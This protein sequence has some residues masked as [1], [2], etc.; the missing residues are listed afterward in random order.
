MGSM[1]TKSL[2][3][4]V[5]VA[6]TALVASCATEPPPFP[7]PH[8]GGVNPDSVARANDAAYVDP[9]PYAAAVT[10]VEIEPGRKMEIWYPAAP[11][12][13]VGHSPD[14]YHLRDFL[15]ALITDVLPAS[16][17]P[18]FTTTAFRDLPASPGGPFPMVLFSH[19]A[20]SYRDQSSFLTAHLASWGFV[21]I[22]PDYFERGIQTLSGLATVPVP[23][24]S[25]AD[26]TQLAVDEAIALNTGTGTLAGKIDTTR[27]FPIGHS[28]GGSQSTQ[29]AG[30]R[31]DVQS[32]IA[33]SS[34]V[35]LTPSLFN[36]TP[37][38][39][40]ALADPNKTVMWLVGAND[41]VA[42][43]GGVQTAFNY[44]AGER[45]LVVVPLSGH[46]NAMTDICEISRPEGGL[47]GLANT[48]LPFTLPEFV[49]N[50]A[51]DGCISPPNYQGPQVWPIVRQFVTAELRYRSGLD[52]SPVGLGSGVVNQFA[53]VPTYSHN[54]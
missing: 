39:P 25:S 18:S 44:S 37:T 3:A 28:A 31:T 20:I 43:P 2:A 12:S 11:A 13:A 10:T 36:P 33:M 47:V 22:S 17:D 49:T 54:E 32:W 16:V 9:G 53:V 41:N 34:G 51:N 14:T 50:L 46:N 6:L 42:S 24:R 52:T 26:V 21:V 35:N 1:R 15:P 45:K 40:V 38:V 48:Y 29:L 27:L 8:T 23:S 30:S 19:G 4:T 7:T 5:M